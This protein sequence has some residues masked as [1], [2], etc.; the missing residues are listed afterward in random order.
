MSLIS[1]V[2]C[3][4]FCFFNVENISLKKQALILEEVQ[5]LNLENSEKSDPL[6]TT[7]HLDV[8]AGEP[9]ED[10]QPE[11]TVC[12]SVDSLCEDSQVAENLEIVEVVNQVE[13]E[14]KQ[15]ELKPE[16]NKVDVVKE[17]EDA[18]TTA[19][20]KKQLILPLKEEVPDLSA[21]PEDEKEST[22]TR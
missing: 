8:E 16:E 17:I 11:V 1:D 14:G 15:A 19:D 3:F 10:Q 12:S 5:K 6:L 2:W 22:P 18:S 13:V 4:V 21:A 20:E 9:P 7:E